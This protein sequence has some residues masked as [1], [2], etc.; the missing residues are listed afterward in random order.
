MLLY[1]VNGDPTQGATTAKQKLTDDCTSSVIFLFYLFS[2]RRVVFIFPT[3]AV[4]TSV[5]RLFVHPRE[6]LGSGWLSCAVGHAR[7]RAHT[8]AR[9]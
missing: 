8:H 3:R 9:S 6:I 5:F 1:D 4:L 2:F 7:T